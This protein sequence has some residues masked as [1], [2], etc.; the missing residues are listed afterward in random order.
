[1]VLQERLRL[2]FLMDYMELLPSW[3]DH[4]KSHPILRFSVAMIRFK[5]SYSICKK[6][7]LPSQFLLYGLGKV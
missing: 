1:M 7:R 3:K 4:L 6:Y 2:V 5:N